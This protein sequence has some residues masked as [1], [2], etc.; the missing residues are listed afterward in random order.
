MAETGITDLLLECRI[1][2]GAVDRVF[3]LIYEELRQVAHRHLRRERP[4]HTL[5]TT[6]LV[7][8][9]YIRMVDLTRV[10]WQDRV[11]FLSMAARAMRRILVDHARAHCAERRGRGVSPVALDEELVAADA[12]A[13]E[14]AALDDALARLNAYS[15]RLVQV[16]EYRFFAGMTEEEA[17]TA[18]GVTP[19]TIRRDWVKARGL[20]R[21]AL[22]AAPLAPGS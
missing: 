17:A 1:D 8:E 3:P 14:L 10:E 18:L 6:A 15:P 5:G 19:R 4:G 16:V 7:H 20:L 12:E 13:D 22:D 2:G 9:A 11:H 21:H